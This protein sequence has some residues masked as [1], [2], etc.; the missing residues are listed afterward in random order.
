MAQIIEYIESFFQ[1]FANN[2][3]IGIG[4]VVMLLGLLLFFK[5]GRIILDVAFKVILSFAGLKYLG[6]I[7]F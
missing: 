6:I 1:A 7:T 5:T 3:E 2:P 4:M